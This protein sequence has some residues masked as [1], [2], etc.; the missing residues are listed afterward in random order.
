MMRAQLARH[1]SALARTGDGRFL[2]AV[3]VPLVGQCLDCGDAGAVAAALEQL[4]AALAALAERLGK[5]RAEAVVG[6]T[7]LP[8]LRGAFA[9]GAG[10]ERGLRLQALEVLTGLLAG[11]SVGR[12]ALAPTVLP[13]LKECVMADRSAAVV[14]AV[15]AA[16]EAAASGPAPVADAVQIG[17][18]VLPMLTALS[19]EADL[20]ATGFASVVAAVERVL[21]VLVELRGAEYSGAGAGRGARGAAS[22][23]TAT[24][25]QMPPRLA[26]L[27]HVSDAQTERAPARPAAPEASSQQAFESL[28]SLASLASLAPMRPS[29]ETALQPTAAP[30][31][32]PPTP[33]AAATA[34]MSK[35]ARPADAVANADEDDPFGLLA[36][37]SASGA[38]AP[39][40]SAQ[41]PS[42]SSSNFDFLS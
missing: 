20:D 18:S 8:R 16:L 41:P 23:A 31:L 37:A 19:C 1:L 28:G 17:R 11:G 9:A 34:A 15:V 10:R 6:A 29:Q 35:Q 39:A 30:L 3:V 42:S 24:A 40:S 7:V 4:P 32:L 25:R 26:A 12:A 14:L 38:L 22:T 21:A 5:G 27:P 13:A 2:D 33:P 36:T